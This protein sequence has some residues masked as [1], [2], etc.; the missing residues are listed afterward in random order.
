MILFF[1]D[2]Y[3]FLSLILFF[4]VLQYNLVFIGYFFMKDNTERRI[5]IILKSQFRIEVETKMKPFYQIIM[6]MLNI[7][8]GLAFNIIGVSPAIFNMSSFYIQDIY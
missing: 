5:S 4:S 7:L 1:V 3:S 2:S 8:S 6:L